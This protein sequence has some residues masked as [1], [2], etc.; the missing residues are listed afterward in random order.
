ML[1]P[2][3]RSG[4]GAGSGSESPHITVVEAAQRPMIQAY[5][6]GVPGRPLHVLAALWRL[7]WSPSTRSM[8]PGHSHTS[9]TTGDPQ[10][11]D[12]DLRQS[13]MCSQQRQSVLLW[14]PAIPLPL[15]HRG[16]DV[17]HVRRALH[18]NG[19]DGT[20]FFARGDAL[21]VLL[22]T[23]LLDVHPTV[24]L[25]VPRVWEKMVCSASL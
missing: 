8:T 9:V 22:I 20:I 18:R 13:I 14:A 15:S 17:G 2:T 3:I 4:K 5:R 24:F 19:G 6:Q 11:H 10:G 21:K 12:A 23:A 1:R 16:A 25:D 7:A